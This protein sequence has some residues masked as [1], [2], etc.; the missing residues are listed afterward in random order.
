MRDP[1]AE[2]VH[3]GNLI[4]RVDSSPVLEIGGRPHY[5]SDLRVTS[6]PRHS[7]LPFTHN[8]RTRR[9]AAESGE[10]ARREIVQHSGIYVTKLDIMQFRSALVEPDNAVYV[11]LLTLRNWLKRNADLIRSFPVAYSA[12]AMRG[13]KRI[14]QENDFIGAEV[15]PA[16]SFIAPYV[17]EGDERRGIG[18]VK[19]PRSENRND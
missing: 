16:F 6:Q 18:G 11:G 5:T 3:P 10:T 9:H 2:S 7:E 12:E 15:R 13:C 4:T 1:F 17:A 14:R 19:G 8:P